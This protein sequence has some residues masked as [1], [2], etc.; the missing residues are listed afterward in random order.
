M[1]LNSYLKN[2]YVAACKVQHGIFRDQQMVDMLNNGQQDFELVK[3]WMQDYGLFQGITGENRDAIVKCFLEFARL[4][5]RE[6]K[7]TDEIVEKLYSELFM[8]LYMKVPRSWM[9]ATSKL[10]WCL[11]PKDIAIYD[12]FV[13]R[14]LVVM[15]CIDSNLSGFPRVGTAPKIKTVDDIKLAIVHYMR[16]QSII[17]KLLTTHAK[18]LSSLRLANH[19][20]YPYD[21]RILDKILWMIGNAKKSLE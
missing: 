4:H 13:H 7:V 6:S 3:S 10:L 16:Y 18:T 5:V 2:H 20:K 8:L 15:Q 9:S 17:R 19:E 14:T 21:I 1:S 11:Y 12:A